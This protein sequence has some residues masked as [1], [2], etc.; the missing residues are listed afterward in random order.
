MIS[1]A[2]PWDMITVTLLLLDT[3]KYSQRYHF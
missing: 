2:R 1:L 3:N